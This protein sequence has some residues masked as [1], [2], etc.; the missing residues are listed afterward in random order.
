MKAVN[1]AHNAKTP[2]TWLKGN[3][4]DFPLIAD[5]STQETNLWG[6]LFIKKEANFLGE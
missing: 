4:L 2:E 6:C 3:V 1:L 5:W